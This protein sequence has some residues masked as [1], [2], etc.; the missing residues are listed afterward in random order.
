MYFVKEIIKRL[1]DSK[2]QLFQ[3]EQKAENVE[4]L[5]EQVQVRIGHGETITG[6]KLTNNRIR[7]GPLSSNILLTHKTVLGQV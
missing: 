2:D 4:R 1:D 7:L 6:D 5:N 3:E